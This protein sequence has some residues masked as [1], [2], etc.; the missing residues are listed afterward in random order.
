MP[1]KEVVTSD[2]KKIQIYDGLFNTIEMYNFE[3]FAQNSYYAITPI[4]PL[5]PKSQGKFLASPFSEEDLF[6]FGIFNSKSSDSIKSFFTNKQRVR[7]WITCTTHL[8]EFYVHTDA[9]TDKN[10]ITI[11]YYVNNEWNKEWGG[12]TIF[13]NDKNEPEL[14][15][16]FL[17]GRL[18]IFDSTILHKALPMTLRAPPFRFTFSSTYENIN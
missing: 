7:S 8:S 14:I 16:E 9:G 3:I 5:F 11:L 18:V 2:G 15:L 4:T 13:Y 12:E 17:P 10:P 1:T 6:K